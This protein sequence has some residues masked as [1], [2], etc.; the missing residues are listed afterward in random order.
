MIK[1][2]VDLG[3]SLNRLKRYFDTRIKKPINKP[4]QNLWYHFTD[5]I[6]FKVELTESMANFFNLFLDFCLFG[7]LS[8]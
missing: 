5:L 7:M 6:F 3:K 1:K 8:S 4:E 2:Q